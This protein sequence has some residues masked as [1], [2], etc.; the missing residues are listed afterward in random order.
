MSDMSFHK[1]VNNDPT[2]GLI[3]IMV[4]GVNDEMRW[5]LDTKINQL[6]LVNQDPTAHLT[7]WYSGK[8]SVVNYK[9][10]FE[11]GGPGQ[12]ITL[13]PSATLYFSNSNGA[14]DSIFTPSIL[15]TYVIG[16]RVVVESTS[17]PDVYFDFNFKIELIG[18]GTRTEVMLNGDRITEQPS[19]G[20]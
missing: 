14:Y 20:A 18:N 13:A 16:E 19:D 2:H 11:S 5:Y 10:N 3:F 7:A 9:G 1:W 4:G 8:A 15:N 17:S 12:T 6:I